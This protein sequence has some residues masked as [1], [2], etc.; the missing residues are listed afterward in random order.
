VL[1]QRRH[2]ETSGA[3]LAG[4]PR[5]WAWRRPPAGA[6]SCRR[7]AVSLSLRPRC[8]S[9]DGVVDIV[10]HIRIWRVRCAHFDGVRRSSG[11]ASARPQGAFMAPLHG[12]VLATH[13]FRTDFCSSLLSTQRCM[14]RQHVRHLMQDRYT[15][16]L[17]FQANKKEKRRNRFIRSC[18]TS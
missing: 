3:E 7:P 15:R 12:H 6:P 18:Q 8:R 14:A 2:V 1:N 5:K 10:A 16:C 17:C 11:S 4:A 9:A 13:R